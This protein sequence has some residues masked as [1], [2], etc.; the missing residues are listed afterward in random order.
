MAKL[1][2]FT[3]GYLDTVCDSEGRPY[4]DDNFRSAY[5]GIPGL[6]A[7]YQSERLA[8]GKQFITFFPYE[9]GSTQRYLKTSVGSLEEQN[10]KVRVTTAHNSY[11]FHVDPDCMPDIEKKILCLNTIN[12][13]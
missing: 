10:N 4:L 9:S 2:K 11:S 12:R 8:P 3:F 7:L 1:I 6:I 5:Y 13:P